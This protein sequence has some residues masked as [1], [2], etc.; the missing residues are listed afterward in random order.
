MASIEEGD[1]IKDSKA[2][3]LSE[4][5]YNKRLKV[6]LSNPIIQENFDDSFIP[7]I[8]SDIPEKPNFLNLNGIEVAKF[9]MDRTPAI[10]N[11]IEKRYRGEFKD[12]LGEF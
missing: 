5:A 12:L 1:T 10:K 2:K 9:Y 11:V 4:E 3:P 7:V 6:L 8:F